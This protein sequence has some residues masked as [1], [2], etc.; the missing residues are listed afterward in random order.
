MS[1]NILIVEDNMIIQMFL[2]HTV[3]EIGNNVIKTANN[4]EE[5]LK[6]IELERPDLILMDIG[7]NGEKNGIEVALVVNEKYGIPI[8]FITG[9]SDEA[10]LEKAIKTNPVHIIHK[11][12][13]E[14]QLKMEISAIMEKISYS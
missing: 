9:N 1:I 11:P 5:A 8:V 4:G 12:I 3:Q 10:T 13:D 7:L 6:M 14:N 2:E